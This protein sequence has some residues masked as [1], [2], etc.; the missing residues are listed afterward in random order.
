MRR[1]GRR[2]GAGSRNPGSG[3]GHRPSARRPRQASSSAPGTTGR[4]PW[5]RRMSR[6]ARPRPAMPRRWLSTP[7]LPAGPPP[8]S[9]G[10]RPRCRRDR[11][12]AASATI[13]GDRASSLCADA[14]LANLES[15]SGEPATRRLDRPR[16][17]VL[18]RGR[19]HVSRSPGARV[20][21][22]FVLVLVTWVELVAANEGEGTVHHMTVS[23]LP[24]KEAHCELPPTLSARH[25][26]SGKIRDRDR[27]VTS[28][29]CT[30]PVDHPDP[31]P[32]SSFR[33]GLANT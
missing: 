1:R 6:R 23:T 3:P 24:A 32:R 14:Q 4:A 8:P 18:R 22:N 2:S 10:R 33:T 30:R 25:D 17:K 27:G 5:R 21:K 29:P 15:E 28:R 20:A 11:P 19:D 9:P 12:L 31:S 13:S 7:G 16:R 26:G